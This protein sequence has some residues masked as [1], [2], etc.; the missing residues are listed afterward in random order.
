MTKPPKRRP[1]G[2]FKDP[3]QRKRRHF[4]FRLRDQLSTSLEQEAANNTRSV[5]EEIEHRLERSFLIDTIIGDIEAF[6]RRSMAAVAQQTGAG[7]IWDP[8]GPRYF[9]P[10]THNIPQS[11]FVTEAEAAAPPVPA[12]PAAVHEAI[13]IAVR[14]ALAE[15][16]PKR[17]TGEAA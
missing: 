6:R 9:A 1:G 10:G 8:A 5:S 2:Q 17:K 7:K 4:T 14:D 16:L 3:A 12:L 15:L 11:G 13:R